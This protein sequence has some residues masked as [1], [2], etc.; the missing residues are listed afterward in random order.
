MQAKAGSSG[1]EL[2]AD[3]LHV[4]GDR[5][6]VHHHARLAHEV[7]AVLHVARM[8]G[9]R[10]HH[11]ELG[12]GQLDPLAGPARGDALQV[13]PQ[14]AAID[15]V[16]ARGI[17]SHRV[18]APEE[19]RDARHEVRQA[20]VLREVV[21]GAQPQAGDDVELAIARGEEEDR[22]RGRER[23]QL[24]AEGEAPVDL[25]PE[26]DVDDRE[27]RQARAEGGHGAG[28][29]GEGRDLVALPPQHVGVV[30]AERGVV[31][32]D[33]DASAHGSAPGLLAWNIA[34]RPA[35]WSPAEQLPSFCPNC[36]PSRHFPSPGRPPSPCPMQ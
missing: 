8:A 32:D 20:D 7:V 6:V 3:A 19:R 23:A 18:D 1:Q 21:V 4:R 9:E 35:P 25:G 26:P 15:H 22:E 36:S 2:P 12:E 30:L 28:P 17:R 5:A 29:I 13:E 31:L 34:H 16:L 24:A 14:P 11:P 33:G 10:V 27:I